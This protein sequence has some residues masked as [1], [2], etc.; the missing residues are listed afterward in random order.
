MKERELE[1]M[2]PP[3]PS[4]VQAEKARGESAG[5]VVAGLSGAV[6][7]RALLSLE[8]AVFNAKVAFHGGSGPL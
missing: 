4:F 5:Q 1:K 8:R 3:S 2:L 6:L 7:S